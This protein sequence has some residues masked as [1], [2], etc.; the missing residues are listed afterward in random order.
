MN[1]T[2][3][4]G[5]DLSGK[6]KISSII[7]KKL[8]VELR[9][10]LLFKDRTK[11]NELI[12]YIR[13]NNITDKDKIDVFGTIYQ[14]DLDNYLKFD[15]LKNNNFVQ[16]NYGIIRNIAYF[17]YMGYKVDKLVEI[18]KKYPQSETCFYFTCTYE[19]RI[20]RLL[21][22]SIIKKEDIYEKLLR[23]NPEAFL[24]IDALSYKIYNQFF[25]SNL[26]DNTIQTEEE[27]VQYVLK[28][29]LKND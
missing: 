10:N 23:Q 12:N 3:F 29:V 19:E 28:K 7:S 21:M 2:V 15:V 8:N 14:D 24:E 27:T 1:G 25:D 13:I 9:K 26:L 20:K 22:R 11:Y 4:I 18:L 6:S 5:M 17:Q 16:D